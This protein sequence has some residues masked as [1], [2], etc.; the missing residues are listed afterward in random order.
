MNNSVV[1]KST[2]IA[3]IT[4]SVLY[5][6]I[7]ST[8]PTVPAPPQPDLSINPRLFSYLGMSP[9]EAEEVMG[10][11]T[12][13]FWVAGHFH[14]F[15]N[16]TVGFD[17]NVEE[18]YGELSFIWTTLSGIVDGIPSEGVAVSELSNLFGG[19]AH[20][21][22]DPNHFGGD[23]FSGGSARYD[24]EGVMVA[25]AINHLDMTADSDALA[26]IGWWGG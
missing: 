15:G 3:V 23:W 8:S 10:T 25:I 24:H 4:L 19:T 13:S 2:S 20:Y 1:L 26:I 18:P 11:H 5:I 14:T 17:G 12:S 7:Y 6:L 9:Q 21:I 22:V 16:Y